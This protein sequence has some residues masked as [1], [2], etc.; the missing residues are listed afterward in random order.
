MD[1]FIEIVSE[2]LQT[3]AIIL[4][5]EIGIA[6]ER[7]TELDDSF[8]EGLRSLAT[9]QVRG[10]LA[11]ILA[12]SEPPYLLAE[13]KGLG[14]PF[15]NIFGYCTTLGPLTDTEANDLIASSPI[16]FPTED[17]KWIIEHSQRWPI[18]LQVLCRERLNVLEFGEEDPDWRED[19]LRQLTPFKHLL[20]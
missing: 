19:A 1:N 15:F 2:S 11:F 13:Q 8:W 20:S 3:P 6:I 9:N 4:M 10:N 18:L 16:T 17:T 7:Y 12:S 5:D 14:S